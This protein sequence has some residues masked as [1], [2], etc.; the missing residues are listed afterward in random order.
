[1]SIT[2]TTGATGQNG[3]ISVTEETN[4]C[5]TSTASTLAVT[6]GAGTPAQP[7]AITGTTPVCPGTSQIYSVTAVA[8][9]TTYTWS[10]PAGW[11]ITAGAGTTSI[12]VTT[13]A[14]GQNGNISV[15]AGNTCGTSTVKHFSGNC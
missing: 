3:N 1:M 5:G 2:V 13:G 9:A 4:T 14:T 15:T 12:T 6:V 7:G 8:G 11:S 10:V